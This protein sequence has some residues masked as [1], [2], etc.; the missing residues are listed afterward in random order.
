SS[1]TEEESGSSTEEESSSTEEE[2]S[3]T[4]EESSS[5]EE[6]SNS[7]EEESS[8]PT[9]S[10]STEEESGSSTEEE[11]SS[12]EEE[13]GS[14]TEEENSSTEESSTEESSTEESSTP[15]NAD[16]D[17]PATEVDLSDK[18]QISIYVPNVISNGKNTEQH[19][20]PVVTYTYTEN[21]KSVSRKLVEGWQYTLETKAGCDYMTTGVL[22]TYVIKA[23]TGSGFTGSVERSYTIYDKKSEDVKA[24][25]KL[26]IK[27]AKKS[28]DFTG[29]A[30]EPEISVM[31]GQTELEQGTD[32]DVV[33]KN[34]YNAGK[35]SV[36]VIGE[37]SYTGTKELSFTIKKFKFTYKNPILSYTKDG[38]K[39]A[40][41]A[42]TLSDLSVK[43]ASGY[44]LEEGTDYT[45]SYKS[46]IGK[47]TARFTVKAAGNNFSGSTIEF[48]EIE[49]MEL[50]DIPDSAL[51]EIEVGYSSKGAKL[52][53]IKWGGYVL[54]E[55]TDY[56]VNYHYASAEGKGKK[57]GDV[58]PVEII[59]K[60]RWLKGQRREASIKVVAADFETLSVKSESDFTI[61]T[62][63]WSKR[64]S[65]VVVKDYT[66]VKLKLNKD[67]E[68][69]WDESDNGQPAAG[70]TLTISPINEDTYTGIK[71]VTYRVASKISA[72]NYTISDKYFNGKTAVT[73]TPADIIPKGGEP[74]LSAEDY[75]VTGYKN[76]A[77]AGK[78]SVTLKGK[79]KYY[80]TITLKFTIKD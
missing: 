54:K 16:P 38:Y 71:T 9:E 63:K 28:Y 50:S 68:L 20:T 62:G 57:V 48:F 49:G 33:Y 1:S 3:S 22:Q 69:T 64:N 77:K 11:S 8:T 39:Y 59:G 53:E 60:N 42:V 15:D 56:R 47:G 10:S 74:E 55:G 80:G 45:V 46:N 2:S 35:A 5:T 13:S 61:E 27:L 44:E 25:S 36:I 31:D 40:G 6:E 32:Y 43:L 51:S 78:A 34:N 4:E 70:L 37:G 79:G 72:K 12:T 52:S 14:S 21:G 24:V 17:R 19:S 18:S 23:V 67:Y 29:Y 75:E 65:Q 73:I 58:V 76:N 26:S 30:I 41:S 7:T 66:G